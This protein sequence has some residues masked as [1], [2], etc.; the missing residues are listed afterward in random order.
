MSKKVRLLY[1]VLPS[2]DMPHLTSKIQKALE[3]YTSKIAIVKSKEDY[4]KLEDRYTYEVI[5]CWGLPGLCKELI[6]D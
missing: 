6:T 5:A 2:W 1:I 4:F 3:T